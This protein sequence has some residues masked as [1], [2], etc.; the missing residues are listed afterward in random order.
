MKLFAQFVTCTFIFIATSC[1]ETELADLILHNAKIYT[2]NNAFDIAEAMVIS[3]GKIVAIGPEHEIRNKY[4][5]KEIID[6]RKRPIYPGFIDSHCHFINYSSTKNRVNLTRTKSF[7]EVLQK[8]Q[9]FSTKNDTE[10]IFGYGWD[11]NDWK[12]KEFPT[13][14]KLDSLFPS[15]P[16]V[17][18]R[19]DGHV[20][21]VNGEVLRRSNI[22]AQSQ[23]EG[24]VI[25]HQPSKNTSKLKLQN[26]NREN[27]AKEKDILPLT[28]ILMDNA[29]DLI[30]YKTDLKTS[31]KTISKLLIEEQ[32]KLFGVG[33]TSIDE[34]GLE[35]ETIMLIDSLQQEKLLKIKM[36]I[37]ASSSEETLNYYLKRGPYKT[38][39]LNVCSFK[40]IAD[41][42]LGSRGACL[43]APYSDVTNDEQGHMIHNKDYFEKYAT[44]LYEKGFQMNTHCIGDSANRLILEVY[45]KTLKSVNDKRWRIEHAQIIHPKDLEYFKNYTIIPS[46]Q[47]AHATSDKH[48]A[49]KRLGSERIKSAYAHKDLLTQN[50]IIALGTDFPVE[51]INPIK[52]FY[53]AVVRKD[54]QGFPENGYQMENALSRKEALKGMTIWAAIAN[55]EENE[56]GSLEPGKAAD[57]VILE[58]DIMN[59]KESDILKVAVLQTFING[60]NVYSLK[61]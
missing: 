31:N 2:V 24:G 61:K 39:L 32:N 56:K 49:E 38:D 59:I 53:A 6:G 20:K 50:G 22:T 23:I 27:S 55:F 48:W 47:P 7:N 16:V 36:Y 10:W 15:T 3:D 34:A 19:I 12:N 52:T 33:L 29:M 54:E 4:N 17:L 51:E 35:K 13:R 30:A 26:G 45:A 8:L 21:L 18:S 28:G 57:F 9:N 60:E 25:L 44:K 11:Q 14:E 40:F 46:I 58:N 43:L 5:A 37:M 42:A 41:G 1:T